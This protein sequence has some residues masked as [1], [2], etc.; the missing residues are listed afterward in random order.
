MPSGTIARL[1]IDKGFGFIRDESGVEHFFHR[2][3]VRGRGL[4]G[5]A[6][7]RT[8]RRVLDRRITQGSESRGMCDTPALPTLF[9]L[10][11]PQNGPLGVSPL[12]SPRPVFP[13]LRLRYAC[14]GSQRGPV[15]L[16]VFKTGRFPRQR[17]KGGFDSHGV[18]PRKRAARDVPGRNTRQASCSVLL[19]TL[20]V[21]AA[22]EPR[23]ARSG[24][25]GAPASERAGCAGDEVP[26]SGTEGSMTLKD[27]LEI[28]LKPD[29]SY[30]PEQPAGSPA[31][32]A[33]MHRRQRPRGPI[34]R[35]KRPVSTANSSRVKMN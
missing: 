19:C 31:G 9:E 35:S 15:A 3:A 34:R 2:S 16:P 26:R 22:S 8:T 29:A 28:G 6:A 1:L 21:S 24:D 11:L 25:C 20:R 10:Q 5:A 33:R 23:P 14:A 17:G 12:L 13:L 4:L 32:R 30:R 7:R 18:P 27:K